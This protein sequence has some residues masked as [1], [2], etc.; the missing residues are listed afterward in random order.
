MK[1][2]AL[3]ICLF[4]FGC[5]SVDKRQVANQQ[6]YLEQS[7]QNYFSQKGYLLRLEKLIALTNHLLEE[8]P[9]KGHP[10]KSLVEKFSSDLKKSSEK[11]K[12]ISLGIND[13]GT[14]WMPSDKNPKAK[15]IASALGE[16]VQSYSVMNRLGVYLTASGVMQEDTSEQEFYF[17]LVA[18]SIDEMDLEIS[19]NI[20]VYNTDQAQAQLQKAKIDYMQFLAALGRENLSKVISR[21]HRNLFGRLDQTFKELETLNDAEKVKNFS[22]SRTW[23]FTKNY[24]NNLSIEG[25]SEIDGFQDD[26]DRSLKTKFGS[27]MIQFIFESLR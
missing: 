17:N 3:S 6:D 24:L 21:N 5:S 11:I 26:I 19:K 27:N 4:I 16:I 12:K 23:I 25:S 18:K 7:Y 20:L 2:V 15:E 8:M 9:D 22:K 14:S 1:F 13:L 10:K